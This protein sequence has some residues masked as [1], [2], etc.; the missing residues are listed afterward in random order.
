[1]NKLT[2]DSLDELFLLWVVEP[3]FDS[4]FDFGVMRKIE[5]IGGTETRR[6]INAI[7]KVAMPIKI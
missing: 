4:F 7:V 1:M 2:G 3:S 5:Q 6:R